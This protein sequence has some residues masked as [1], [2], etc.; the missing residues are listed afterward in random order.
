MERW[1]NLRHMFPK[2]GGDRGLETKHGAKIL[3][4]KN[5][6]RGERV[7]ETKAEAPVLNH[8]DV[9]KKYGGLLVEEKWPA[10]PRDGDAAGVKQPEQLKKNNGQRVVV[11]VHQLEQPKKYDG[12]IDAERRVYF[13]RGGAAWF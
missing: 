5:D 3:M 1:G 7:V 4:H 11:A 8:L 6:N 9:L 10:R 12:H 13:Q 2:V